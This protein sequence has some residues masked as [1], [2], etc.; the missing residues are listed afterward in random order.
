M[1]EEEEAIPLPGRRKG[2]PTALRAPGLKMSST[3]A[4]IDM[5]VPTISIGV[6]D[7]TCTNAMWDE[8]AGKMSKLFSCAQSHSLHLKIPIQAEDQ[9]CIDSEV[10]NQDMEKT[11]QFINSKQVKCIRILQIGNA[12]ST[13]MFDALQSLVQ[14][15]K[16]PPQEKIVIFVTCGDTE[17]FSLLKF[18][19][20]LCLSEKCN[21]LEY[22][23]V[24][25]Y[26]S[27]GFLDNRNQFIEDIKRGSHQ[28]KK[29]KLDT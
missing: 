7:N 29:R 16:Q 3:S 23:D 9:R 21:N 14:G 17:D 2:I 4:K 8:D 28:C 5:D 15:W 6:V 26:N 25:D 20:M 22:Y 24:S 11:L 19:K 10:L 27:Y 1:A 12:I 13:A 18:C